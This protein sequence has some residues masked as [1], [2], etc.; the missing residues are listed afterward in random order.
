H[1][2][3]DLLALAG[4]AG[5]G[6]GR[7]ELHV[8][9]VRDDRDGLRPVL[10]QGLQGLG[11]HGTKHGPKRVAGRPRV[12]QAAGVIVISEV[13]RTDEATLRAFWAVEQASQRH[14]R[15]HAM[16]RSWDRL[17]T[18]AQGGNEYYARTFLVAR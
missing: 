5:D 16:L 17:H 2:V 15:E 14:D 13:D 4:P 6:R 18:L 10:G 1:H 7:A 11:I 3:R 8:V 12:R 9:G